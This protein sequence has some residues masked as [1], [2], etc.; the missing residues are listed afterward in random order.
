[1]R[2]PVRPARRHRRGDPVRQE[3]RSPAGRARRC[4]SRLPPRRRR[5]RRRGP[6]TSTCPRTPATPR[7]VRLPADLGVGAG[8]GRERG[9]RGRRQ[10]HDLHDPRSAVG[11]RRPHRDGPRAARAGALR[12]ARRRR[13]P[14]RASCWRGRA[15]RLRATPASGGPYWSS[16]LLADPTA[17]F[18]VETSGNE[19]AVEAVTVT[20]ATSNRTTIPAFDAAHR[21]PR[22]PVA[23]LVDPRL[24]RLRARRW[25]A[26]RS[27][28]TSLQAHLASHEGGAD[29]WTV[30]MH[31]DGADHRE[32]TTAAMVAELPVGGPPIVH[33]LVGSPCPGTWETFRF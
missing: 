24:R 8:A 13:G 6:P 32:A 12:A 26:G 1:M 28:S 23:T 4:S 2:S 20:R 33:H 14:D 5:R 30:C 31:V 9:G 18:V 7:R 27:R 11:A 15:G 21:H 25:P 10:R 29:G 3:Q 22:Q 17:A 16:F 19:V